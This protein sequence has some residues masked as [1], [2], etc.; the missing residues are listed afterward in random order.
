MSAEKKVAQVVVS[1]VGR[2]AP[3]DS[4]IQLEKDD[5]SLRIQHVGDDGVRKQVVIVPSEYDDFQNAVE[6]LIGNE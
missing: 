3:S 6:E 1:E 2:E 5:E 4:G